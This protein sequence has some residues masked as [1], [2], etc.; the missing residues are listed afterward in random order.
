MFN[1]T[2]DPRHIGTLLSCS[3]YSHTTSRLSLL[4]ASVSIIPSQHGLFFNPSGFRTDINLP[5][6]RPALTSNPLSKQTGP[7]HHRK[8][9]LR[10]TSLP[11]RQTKPPSWPESCGHNCLML[12]S[13]VKRFFYRLWRLHTACRRFRGNVR[14]VR[15]YSTMMVINFVFYF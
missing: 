10:P 14:S 4:F 6:S 8:H 9:G 2:P 13:P 7:A 11:A 1:H 12:P 3:V 15:V 5:S